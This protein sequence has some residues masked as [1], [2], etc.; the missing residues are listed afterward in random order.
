[1]DP[2]LKYMIH[3]INIDEVANFNIRKYSENLSISIFPLRD[4]TR[5]ENN[6]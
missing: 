4:L 5:K 2:H 1:M 6:H 3:F